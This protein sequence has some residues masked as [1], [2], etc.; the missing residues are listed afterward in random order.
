MVF[1]VFEKASYGLVLRASRPLKVL[2]K[3]KNP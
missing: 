3:V 2:D 1:E